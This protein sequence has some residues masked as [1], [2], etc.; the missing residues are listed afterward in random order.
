VRSWLMLMFRIPTEPSALRVSSWRKL[1]RLGAIA[2]HDAVWVL[3]M[4]PTTREQLQWLVS[5][6]A[7]SGGEAT[8]WRS[9]IEIGDATPLVA[10]FRERADSA[11]AEILDELR[12]EDCDV[13]LLARRYQQVKAV[14]YFPSGLGD[15]VREALLAVR[16]GGS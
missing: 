10:Q 5:E 13:P 14:D 2:L 4:T 11:Y 3:P 7:E 6:I 15:Q 1:K 9:E 12:R 8:V 16:G